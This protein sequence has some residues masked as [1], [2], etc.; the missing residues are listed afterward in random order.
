MNLE[1]TSADDVD[2][3]RDAPDHLKHI[4]PESVEAALNGF[5]L[6][7]A[8]SSAW[9][10][11]HIL[12]AIF[13][14]AGAGA[15]IERYP[16]KGAVLRE[17]SGFADQL[18]AFWKVYGERSD[19]A[20]SVLRRHAMSGMDFGNLTDLDALPSSANQADALD[21]LNADK[22]SWWVDGS[23]RAA[24]IS[25]LWASYRSWLNGVP[26]I[27]SF[28][29][30]AANRLCSP[31]DPPRWRDS[32]RRKERISLANELAPVFEEAYGRAA[33]VNSWTDDTGIPNG[34]PWPDY[35]NRIAR[36]ALQVER[37]PDLLGLLKLAR[38]ERLEVERR[39]VATNEG[40]FEGRE[41]G[42]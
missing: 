41:E 28:I 26:E 33:T 15:E 23:K 40:D 11:A 24:A 42:E 30:D 38:Q 3:L 12:R 37:I 20:E 39:Q 1:G 34:G 6:S 27:A 14:A 36:L 5:Q 35:F 7:T 10:A 17:L 19:W 29:R 21:H 16:G 8:K 32:E 18:D 9:M 31:D 22:D 25:P 4:D 2:W 13:M